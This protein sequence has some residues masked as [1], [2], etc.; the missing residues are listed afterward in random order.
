MSRVLIDSDVVLDVLFDRLPF[1]E[2]S[3]RILEMCEQKKIT[4]YLTPVTYSNIYYLL[5][6]NASHGKVI[7]HLNQ[8]LS[9]TEVLTMDKLVIQQALISGFKDFEDALQNYS[10]VKYGKIDVIL[11]RNTKDY[12]KSELAVMTPEEFVRKGRWFTLTRD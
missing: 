11:T 8:L 3:S 7:R 12:I 4:G 6:R 10:A 9:I 1:A 5:R 2:F